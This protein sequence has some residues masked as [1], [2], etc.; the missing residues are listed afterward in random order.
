MLEN[1][2]ASCYAAFFDIDW[3]PVKK[4]LQNKILVPVLGGHYG[5]TLEQQEL[6]LAFDA[7]RGEFSVYYYQHRFPIDPQT[8]PL[9][10][11][12][13]HE[14]L[15]DCFATDDLVLLEYQTIDNSFSKLPLRTE[16]T[17]G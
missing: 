17:A 13:Q 1:G 14:R 7:D 6:K 8:Y 5:N 11:N 16:T 10:L 4:T 12:S 15:L 3:Y 9:I 2:Q